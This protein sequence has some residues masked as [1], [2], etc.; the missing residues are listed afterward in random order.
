[1]HKINLKGRFNNFYSPYN[2][3]HGS[4]TCAHVL[5]IY[6]ATNSTDRLAKR[7][8]AV[9]VAVAGCF[10]SK[11]AYASLKELNHETE[12]DHRLDRAW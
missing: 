3:V 7:T 12:M 2:T 11:E 9:A 4:L 8:V 1:M 10:C 6:I 5:K